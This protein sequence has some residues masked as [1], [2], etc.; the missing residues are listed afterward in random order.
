M[1]RWTLNGYVTI[2]SDK[3]Q[4][5]DEFTLLERQIQGYKIEK[6]VDG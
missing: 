2:D 3:K 5:K 4:F 6:H 1:D